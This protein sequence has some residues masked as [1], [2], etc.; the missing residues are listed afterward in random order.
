MSVW[1][2]V[3]NNNLAKNVDMEVLDKALQNLGGRLD[4]NVKTVKN[5][6]GSDSCD[7]G[8]FNIEENRMT[9]LGILV[10]KNNGIE[11]V[12]DTWRSGLSTDGKQ[13][14]LLNAISQQ[15]AK[16]K[17]TSLLQQTGYVVETTMKDGKIELV[18]T[19]Y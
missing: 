18:G 4:W 15:Y 2:K 3:S 13:Q 10:N 8:I 12:G 6:Y 19:C 1:K 16:E 11:L 5:G 9:A 17:Y 7:A 14:E